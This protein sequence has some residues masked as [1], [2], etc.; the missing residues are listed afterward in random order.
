MDNDSKLIFEGYKDQLITEGWAKLL[1]S[2]L[3]PIAAYVAGKSKMTSSLSEKI[4][5]ATD[6]LVDIEGIMGSPPVQFA[7][8]FD[9]TGLTQ[10]P[11]VEKAIKNYEDDPSSENKFLLWLSLFGT[12]PVIGRFRELMRGVKSSKELSLYAGFFTRF[13]VTILD[14]KMSSVF[15]NPKF[16]IN[17]IRYINSSPEKTKRIIVSFLSLF[18]V[19]WTASALGAGV[20]TTSSL[21]SEA[22]TNTGTKENPT[23]FAF[24]DI[25]NSNT[26]NKSDFIGKVFKNEEDGKYYRIT[27]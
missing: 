27:E 1:M 14:K 5:N 25:P 11:N 24:S 9:P 6:G 23:T 22:S 20:M 15:S 21:G 13:A 16:Q 10:W 7:A 4:K 2:L 26:V 3:A 19:K 17:V 8:V 18:G 12:I